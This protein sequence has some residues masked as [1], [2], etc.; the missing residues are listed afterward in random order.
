[1]R[2]R[3]VIWMLAK[4]LCAVVLVLGFTLSVVGCSEQASG[5]QGCGKCDAKCPADCK[6]PCCAKTATCPKAQS[7]TEKPASQQPA[8]QGQ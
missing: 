8:E 1:M 5:V 2:T 4:Y 3:N 7:G 6:K